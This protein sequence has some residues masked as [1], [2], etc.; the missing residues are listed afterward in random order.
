[1]QQSNVSPYAYHAWMKQALAHYRTL[2]AHEL[3]PED[4]LFLRRVWVINGCGSNPRNVRWGIF[5][6]LF[7]WLARIVA[8]WIRPVF[9]EASCDLHDFGYWKGWDEER[10][11]ECD[12]KFY[13]A[14]IADIA[15]KDYGLIRTTYYTILALIFYGFV[16]IGGRLSFNYL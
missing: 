13:E 8:G 11:K 5:V 4:I 10:R 2:H 12:T 7:A 6:R 1:M 3:R 15:R 16:R 9:F 14:I